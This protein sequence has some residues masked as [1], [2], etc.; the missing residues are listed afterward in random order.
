M[1]QISCPF[2]LS[3]SITY[4]NVFPHCSTFTGT[5][6]LKAPSPA[7]SRRVLRHDGWGIPPL[8]GDI[9]PGAVP[10]D[11]PTCSTCHSLHQQH[12]VLEVSSQ[13]SQQWPHVQ[14]HALTCQPRVAS[15]PLVQR[16][17]PAPTTADRSG[18]QPQELH[19]LTATNSSTGEDLCHPNSSWGKRR[20]C[21]FLVPCER[22]QRLG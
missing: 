17:P 1:V 21:C 15:W 9:T 6:K 20:N 16:A 8:G 18:L 10:R 19:A 22:Q 11:L 12:E 7:W 13:P 14:T 3:S 4:S 2:Y 5:G